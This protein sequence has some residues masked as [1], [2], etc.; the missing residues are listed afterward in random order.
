MSVHVGSCRKLIDN[1]C[2]HM[3]ASQQLPPAPSLDCSL[4]RSRAHR[5]PT[6]EVQEQAMSLYRS[7][8]L[9]RCHSVALTL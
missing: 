8:T 5:A 6:Q 1:N 7:D 9:S 3:P 2:H 4:S